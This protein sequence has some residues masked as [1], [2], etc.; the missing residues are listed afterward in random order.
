LKPISIRVSLSSSFAR[1]RGD[2][3]NVKARTIAINPMTDPAIRAE[4]CFVMG[5]SPLQCIIKIPGFSLGLN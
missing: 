5:L 1:A 2:L 3:L 4:E